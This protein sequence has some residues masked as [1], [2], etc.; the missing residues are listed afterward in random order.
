M[1]KARSRAWGLRKYLKKDEKE[2]LVR[3]IMQ[4]KPH[5]PFLHNGKPILHRLLRYCKENNISWESTESTTQHA[6]NQSQRSPA[7]NDSDISSATRSLQ[8]L[9]RGHFQLSPPITIYGNMRVNETIVWTTQAYLS[10]YF[11]TGPGSRLYKADQPLEA[12]H[13]S[14]DQSS[15]LVKNEEAWHG[16]TEPLEVTDGIHEALLALDCV[17][18]DTAFTRLQNHLSF[19][20]FLLEQQ[21]P[22]L[23]PSLIS[24][25]V[26]VATQASDNS[27]L[28][29]MVRD[30]ILEMAATVLSEA[31]PITVI[32]YQLS[33]PSL[34]AEKCHVWRAVTDVF[35]NAFDILK[36]PAWNQHHR[37]RFISGLKTLGFHDE[38]ETYLDLNYKPSNLTNIFKGW[39]Y[40]YQK[41][42]LSSCRGDYVNAELYLRKCFQLWRNFESVP[43]FTDGRLLGWYRLRTRCSVSLANTLENMERIDEAKAVMRQYFEGLHDGYSPD[44]AHMQVAGC[45]YDDFLTHH[46]YIEESMA[47]R[48]QHPWLLTRN[49]IPKECL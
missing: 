23:L 35:S 21:L 30:Y 38:A 5:G 4:S 33:T 18:T 10:T 3:Q 48:A 45:H 44:V 2:R 24:I 13:N 40:Y 15:V 1:Y 20:K 14:H 25:L 39:N 11:V 31:H 12:C 17:L 29:R 28:A 7:A 32:L 9:F 42:D 36:T 46:G 37:L 6:E 22:D 16:M 26:T 8:S 43:K 27:Q 47:L 41:G 49:E 19:V 34:V